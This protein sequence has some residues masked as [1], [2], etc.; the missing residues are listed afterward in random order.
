MIIQE[1]EKICPYFDEKTA[2][3]ES[4]IEKDVSKGKVQDYL[5]RGF[6]RFGPYFYRPVC[7]SCQLCKSLRVDVKNFKPSSGQRRI[8]KKSTELKVEFSS[9]FSLQEAFA[10]WRKFNQQKFQN[11]VTAIDFNFTL[12]YPAES[13]FYSLFSYESKLVGIGFLDKTENSLSSVYFAYDLDYSHLSLG[14]FS[15]LKELEFAQQLGISHYYLG[16]WIKDLS[17]MDYKAGYRPNEILGNE[18]WQS[19]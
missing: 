14:H 8:L 3:F 4:V 10:L 12:A 6:R 19:N 13:R 1:E 15:I 5:E 7:P 18:G 17:S 16:Y 2:R 11:E 9:M